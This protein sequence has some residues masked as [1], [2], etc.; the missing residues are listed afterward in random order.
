MKLLLLIIVDY[1]V[2]DQLL[3]IYTALMKYLRQMGMQ[4]SSASTINRLQESYAFVVYCAG[5]NSLPA[6]CHTGTRCSVLCRMQVTSRTVHYILSHR[7]R[8]VADQGKAVEVLLP[9]WKLRQHIKHIEYN[10]RCACN[11]GYILHAMNMA[12]GQVRAVSVA[13]RYG[14]DGLGIEI[15]WV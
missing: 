10:F 6:S 13:T 12:V 5:G 7:T 8:S 3:I 2:T 11:I 14:L 9:R 4:W 1:D 15:R